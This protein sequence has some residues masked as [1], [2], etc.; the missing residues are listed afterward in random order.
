M[1]NENP[2]VSFKDKVREMRKAQ[3]HYFATKSKDWLNLSMKWEKIVDSELNQPNLFN[4]QED[5]NA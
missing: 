2:P 3:K 4:P 1:I 5:D